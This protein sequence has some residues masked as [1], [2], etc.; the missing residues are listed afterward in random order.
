MNL[1]RFASC[2]RRV[3]GRRVE[4][5]VGPCS[6]KGSA[7]TRP[8]QP[9]V[10][11][12]PPIATLDHAD[13]DEGTGAFFFCPGGVGRTLSYTLRRPLLL[14]GRSCGTSS[15][16]TYPGADLAQDAG[17]FEL[18]VDRLVRRGRHLGWPKV[19]HM[20]KETGRRLRVPRATVGDSVLTSRVERGLR[21][22]RSGKVILG[23]NPYK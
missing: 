13:P 19:W 4:V 6:T 18:G 8:R 12:A 3:K 23:R 5:A 15:M 9:G 7:R 1:R 22:V 16:C 14:P 2:R 10:P 21:R 17:D 11:N 20:D